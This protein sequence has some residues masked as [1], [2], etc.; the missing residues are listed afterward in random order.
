MDIKELKIMMIFYA[1]FFEMIK[2]WKYSGHI[3]K[4]YIYFQLISKMTI[5]GKMQFQ[6][7]TTTSQKEASFTQG[8]TPDSA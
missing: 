1:P 2:I 3:N 4:T 6:K 7:C 8:P 5:H